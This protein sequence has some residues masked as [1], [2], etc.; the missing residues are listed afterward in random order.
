MEDYDGILNCDGLKYSPFENF[1]TFQLIIFLWGSKCKVKKY[2][3][4]D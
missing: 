3:N 1:D 2:Y 4:K